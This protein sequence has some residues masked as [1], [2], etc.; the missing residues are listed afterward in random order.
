[1]VKRVFRDDLGSHVSLSWACIAKSRYEGASWKP[2]ESASLILTYGTLVQV[3]LLCH[4]AE[5]LQF[6]LMTSRQTLAT[7]LEP[8][9][10]PVT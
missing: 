2:A 7:A 5:G 10:K 9:N 6:D 4:I 3:S 8:T 1:M